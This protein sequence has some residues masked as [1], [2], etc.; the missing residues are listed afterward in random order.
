MLRDTR[1]GGVLKHGSV[2]SRACQLK[3]QSFMCT[4]QDRSE[5]SG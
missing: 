4:E 2:V 1:K 5:E 3:I